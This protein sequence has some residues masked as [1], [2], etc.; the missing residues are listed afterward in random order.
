MENKTKTNHGS[1]CLEV[2]T[3]MV[4]MLAGAGACPTLA[5]TD[6]FEYEDDGK[7]IT[8]LTD[9]GRVASSLT[10]PKEV[11]A[12]MSGA[13]EYSTKVSALVIEDGGNPTFGTA[14]FGERANPLSD[15]QVLGSSMTVANIRSLFT[16]LGSQG[17]LSTVYVSGYTGE[18]SDITESTVLT[19]DVSVTL[20]AAL[21]SAQQ[22]GTANIFG[23]FE[24]TKE[25]VTFCG[26][27]TFQDTDDGSNMLFY[28][29]DYCNKDDGYVHIQRVR[30]IKAG[31]GVLIHNLMNTSTHADLPRVSDG[32]VSSADN[33]PYEKN[34]LKGVTV[35][36]PIESTDGANTNLVLSNGAFHP[37]SGG[38]IGAN[39]AYLQV[40]TDVM[41]ARGMLTICFDDEPAGIAITDSPLH[42][43]S[44]TLYPSPNGQGSYYYNLQGRKTEAGT[45]SKGIYISNGKKILKK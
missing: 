1:R 4:A 3:L 35:A 14:L 45:I 2:L 17:S 19:S 33:T 24:M 11:T 28:V 44:S 7:T 34:M 39:K 18:W 32:S 29:A 12:V 42:P 21:V 38:T 40:P 8:R 36:T 9:K 15:I 26:N 25:L 37:T 23:R 13:F 43:S 16:S 20:P 31:Q 5:Q 10:I 22:F 27:A 41:A 6:C 30:Y